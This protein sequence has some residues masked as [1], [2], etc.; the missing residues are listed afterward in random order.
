[1]SFLHPSSSSPSISFASNLSR[2]NR[3]VAHNCN[4][5]DFEALESRVYDL[6]FLEQ[7]SAA[8]RAGGGSSH[9]TNE[10]NNRWKVEGILLVDTIHVERKSLT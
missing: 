4:E 1:M 8:S 3:S 7:K 9:D 6:D 2:E 10:V 5:G